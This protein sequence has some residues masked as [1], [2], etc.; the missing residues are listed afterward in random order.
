VRPVPPFDGRALMLRGFDPESERFVD[1]E[2]EA[3]SIVPAE[4]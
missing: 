1:E 3:Q 2:G 4:R